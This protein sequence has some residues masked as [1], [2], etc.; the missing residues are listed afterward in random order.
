MLARY[1]LIITSATANDNNDNSGQPQQNHRCRRRDTK[2][3]SSK[4][5]N[6]KVSSGEDELLL[7]NPE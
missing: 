7:S 1:H 3:E 5:W 6:I 2:T 4:E